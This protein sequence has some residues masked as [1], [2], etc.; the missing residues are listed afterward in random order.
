[1]SRPSWNVRRLIIEALIGE[2]LSTRDLAHE[3]GES[4][5]VVNRHLDALRSKGDVIR[6]G[7][8]WRLINTDDAA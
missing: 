2:D 1:M 5:F 3:V 7:R 4:V 8:A 6:F